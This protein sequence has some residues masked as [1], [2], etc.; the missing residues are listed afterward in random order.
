MDIYGQEVSVT[1]IFEGL[2]LVYNR[3][4]YGNEVR[5]ADGEVVFRFEFDDKGK[6]S[7]KD[8]FYMLYRLGVFKVM[9]NVKKFWLNKKYRKG[10]L[11]RDKGVNLLYKE[12]KKHQRKLM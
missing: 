6:L 11:K 5:D 2:I 1:T 3:M 10:T 8:M 9:A 12:Y 7:R 4:V